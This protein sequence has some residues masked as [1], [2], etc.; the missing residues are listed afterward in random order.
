M[1]HDDLERGDPVE[2]EL[3]GVWVSATVVRVIVG[4]GITLQ[5]R[6]GSML[7]IPHASRVRPQEGPINAHGR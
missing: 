1:K 3:A 6:D 4:R 2:V 5:L 7:D